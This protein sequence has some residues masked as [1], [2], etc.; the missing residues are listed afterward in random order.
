[1]QDLPSIV[2][3]IGSVVEE[4][5]R[6]IGKIIDPELSD[7]LIAEKRSAYENRTKECAL[8]PTC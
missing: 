3:E 1:M 4:H 5:L 8:T 7:A 6:S 2:A